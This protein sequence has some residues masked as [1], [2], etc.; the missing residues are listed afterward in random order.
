MEAVEVSPAASDSLLLLI[1]RHSLNCFWTRENVILVHRANV[2]W[3]ERVSV[4]WQAKVAR[5]LQAVSSDVLRPRHTFSDLW[6]A[7]K[8]QHLKKRTN[9]CFPVQ[10]SVGF[11]ICGVLWQTEQLNQCWVIAKCAFYSTLWDFAVSHCQWN[12]DT[13]VTKGNEFMKE[14][15]VGMSFVMLNAM[16]MSVQIL[17]TMTLEN[18][19][20]SQC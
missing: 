16:S 5:A 17:L 9:R 18:M 3:I 15:K 19:S 4:I 12:T 20:V 1:G 6:D 7:S 13:A 10:N 2:H 14:N 8:N 11:T